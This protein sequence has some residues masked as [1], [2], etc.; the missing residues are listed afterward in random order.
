MIDAIREWFRRV[1][2]SYQKRSIQYM[3]SISFTIVVEAFCAL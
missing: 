1:T 3:I 2:K